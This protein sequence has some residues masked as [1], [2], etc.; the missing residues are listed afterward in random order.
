MI[1]LKVFNIYTF[2]TLHMAFKISNN[3]KIVIK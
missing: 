1:N 2:K 3:E